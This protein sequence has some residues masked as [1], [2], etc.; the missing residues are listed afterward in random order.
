[1]EPE[2]CSYWLRSFSLGRN[3]ARRSSIV[4]RIIPLHHAQLL[5]YL[6]WTGIHVGL[7]FNFNVALLKDGIVRRVL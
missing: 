6:R 7:L 2:R 5:T 4:E 1:V 3:S